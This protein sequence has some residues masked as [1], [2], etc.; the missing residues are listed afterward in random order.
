MIGRKRYYDAPR[1]LHPEDGERAVPCP[2]PGRP[3]KEHLKRFKLKRDAQQWL[4]SEESKMQTG[5]WVAPRDAKITVAQWCTTW[6]RAYGTRK[7]STVRMAEVHIAKIVAAFGPRRLDSIRESEIK[8]WLVDLK[9]EGYRPSY[10]Y[11]LHARLAQI[12]SDAVHDRVLG[13][14]PTSRRTAPRDGLAAALRGHDKPDLGTA[15][16]DGR[17]VPCGPAAGSV[18]RSTTR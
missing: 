8:S 3:K 7:P 2:L 12:M 5:N 11:A 14:S 16:C 15:R 4:D 1:G 10:I 13:R 18:R 6:L 9:E 17:A